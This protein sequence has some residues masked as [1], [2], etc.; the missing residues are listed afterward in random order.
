[1]KDDFNNL[2]ILG[3]GF[4]VG[5]LICG[6]HNEHLSYAAKK[7]KKKAAGGKAAKGGK[8]KGGADKGASDSGGDTGGGDAAP[9][10][11]SAPTD[12]APSACDCT[13]MPMASDPSKFKIETAAGEDCYNHVYPPS[14]AECEKA[15]VD[16]CAKRGSATDAAPA[17][18]TAAPDTPKKGGAKGGKKGKT[19]TTAFA[20]AYQASQR[21]TVA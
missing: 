3:I 8:A 10:A 15:L 4:I 11:D 19:P 21:V 2:V 20:L 7:K 5:S 18:A 6:V 14:K 9:A 17:D 16:V 12:A 13:C 1:M